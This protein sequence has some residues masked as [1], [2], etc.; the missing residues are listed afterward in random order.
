MSATGADPHSER[1]RLRAGSRIWGLIRRTLPLGRSIGSLFYL[2]SV[3]LIA[4]WI[5][6]VFFGAS[7]Y[8]LMPRSAKLEP[9][10]SPDSARFNDPSA[11][12]PS[13]MGSTSRRDRLSGL[14]PPEA[15]HPMGN[16]A[17]ADKDRP[18]LAPGIPM[19]ANVNPP[20]MPAEATTAHI[21]DEPPEPAPGLNRGQAFTAELGSVSAAAGVAAPIPAPQSLL[22]P[23]PEPRGAS[24]SAHSRSSRKPLARR[25]SNT[26]TAQRHAP[27]NAIEDVLHKH[28]RVLK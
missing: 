1:A 18:V 22:S 3:G 28:S 25:P 10:V 2:I 8:S 23:A 27:V 11:E 13:S 26:R 14:P 19:S 4:G 12:A 16:A 20:P 6:A 9:G 5:I 7:L 17:A 15:A 21:I 24:P